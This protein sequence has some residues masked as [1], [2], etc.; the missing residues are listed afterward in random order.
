M[1]PH[2]FVLMP[3]GV[4]EAL[5]AEP[6][7]NRAT[8][9]AA[10]RIDFDEVYELLIRPALNR[11]GGVPVR[12]SSSPRTGEIRTDMY[13]ELVTADF[14]LADISITEADVFYQLGVRHGALPHGVLLLHGGFEQ[15]PFDVMPEHT[16][17]YDGGLFT[18]PEEGRDGAWEERL[19][20]EV[21]R[22]ANLLRSTIDIEEQETVSP[23]YE[24]LTGLVPVDWRNIRARRSKYF[25]ELFADW[26]LHAS[27]AREQGYPGDILTFADDAPTRFHRA[28]LLWEAADM[29]CEMRRFAAARLVIRDLFI[30]DGRRSET[31]ER[32]NLLLSRIAEVEGNRA[33]A[34]DVVSRR[35]RKVLV[36]SGHMIDTPER[37]RE[38]FPARKEGVVRDQIARQLENWNVGASDLAICGGARGGDILFA[39]LCAERGAEVWLFLAVPETE[40]LKESVTLPRS[41]WERRYYELR[42]RESVKVYVQ[43]ERLKHPPAGVSV[44]SRTNIWM[45]NAARVEADDP[46]NLYALIVWDE[47]PTG[48][49]AGGTS[50]FAARIKRLGGHLAP[51]INP[52]KL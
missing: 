5:S 21:L 11:A 19:A 6:A 46:Q 2:V 1:Q 38:R 14:V 15:H 49:G 30:L 43:S 28:E 45:I 31:Q 25:G 29:L 13:F 32:V 37:P 33:Q 22:L 26:K 7:A 52:T 24:E 27:I 4:K 50:D 18:A 12:A 20:A 51:V 23:V 40:F 34:E 9:K 36:A 8:K 39:E 42:S 16:F 10:V 35:F 41:D 44:Y 3:P 48:D 47:Q 17:D